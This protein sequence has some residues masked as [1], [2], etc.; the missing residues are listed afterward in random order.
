MTSF[1]SKMERHPIGISGFK[2]TQMKMCLS[3]GLVGEVLKTLVSALGL[4]LPWTSLCVT[5]LW[6]YVTD[7]VYV[8]PLPSYCTLVFSAHCHVY[9]HFGPPSVYAAFLWPSQPRFQSVTIAFQGKC[10]IH[11]PQCHFQNC[12]NYGYKNTNKWSSQNNLQG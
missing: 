7:K 2:L 9:S 8:P 6:G 3:N 11:M 10:T 4:P 12:R 1:F 5:F